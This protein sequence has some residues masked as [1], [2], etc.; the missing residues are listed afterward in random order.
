MNMGKKEKIEW[1]VTAALLLV[2]LTAL[3]ARGH[4]GPSGKRTPAVPPSSA[5]SAGPSGAEGTLFSSLREKSARLSLKRDPFYGAQLS[6][7]S[8]ESSGPSGISL[9]GIFWDPEN[10]RAIINGRVAG[11]GD[12]VDGYTVKEI[13]RDRVYLENGDRRTE[14]RLER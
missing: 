9:S 11:A 1:T 7:N 4:G 13:R 5:H 2:F 10:P 6:G 14:L 3:L 8:A 12:E